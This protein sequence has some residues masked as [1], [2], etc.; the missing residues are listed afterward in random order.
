MISIATIEQ[1]QILLVDKP[2]GWSS[3]QAVNKIKWAIRKKLNLKKVKI[4]HAGTLDPLATG[5]LVVCL[6][7]STKQIEQI[8][9]QPKT[10]S[11]RFTLGLTTPSFDA[12]TIPDKTFPT[13]H[14]TPTL[15]KSTQQ[16]FLGEI[17]QYP[18]IFSAI[19]K[20]GQ[21]LYELAR[22]GKSVEIPARQ[23]YIYKFELTAVQ[24]PQVD[25]LIECSKGTYI[26]SIANDFGKALHSGAYL[27]ALRREQIGT[28]SIKEALTPDQWV[29]RIL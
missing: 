13:E 21:R 5:L 7:K 10:Y 12:E 16:Q 28:F 26:R 11:G 8:Q 25:F 18:P 23:V 19:K 14:I 24:M 9:N 17:T 20:D 22:E 29:E 4:G 3:F 6:G 1:G 15:L 27:S 2:L